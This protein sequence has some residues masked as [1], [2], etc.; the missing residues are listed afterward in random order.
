MDPEHKSK[1]E[2]TTASF[3]SLYVCPLSRPPR[4]EGCLS[5]SILGIVTVTNC[6]S[7]ALEVDA[8]IVSSCEGHMESAKAFSERNA[9]T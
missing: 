6:V 3:L 2:A 1:A 9:V 8:V 4:A 5:L 7:V